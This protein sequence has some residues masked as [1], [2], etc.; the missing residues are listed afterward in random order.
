MIPIVIPVYGK[1]DHLARCLT[2]I[3]KNSGHQEPQVILVDDLGPE[4]I[5]AEWL[6]SIEGYEQLTIP[7]VIRNRRN[8]GY[9]GATNA[10]ILHAL[11]R[12]SGWRFLVLLNTDTEPLPSW[13]AS[14]ADT[15]EKA[16]GV[17]VI[18][19]KLLKADDPDQI[20]HGGTMDLLGSH[21]GG[22]ESLGHC[23]KRTD[24][25]WVTGA[26][27]A[28]TR[29][30]LQD[31]G[32]LDRGY[33]HFCSDSDYCLTA[34]SRG[35]RVIYQPE[36]RVLHGHSVTVREAVKPEKIAQDQQRLLDK[37]GGN[38]LQEWLKELP[39]G[40]YRGQPLNATR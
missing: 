19:A 7:V 18:G 24:E 13:L 30:C 1:L 10:G 26:C 5:D 37:W 16:H 25:V 40:L 23:A 34:R 6:R 35:Y 22:R 3:A 14:L 39:M 9:T 15:V 38:M 28:I 2:A 11:W 20:I 12:L 8:L 27:L 36:C 32:L 4:T 21:K 31:C 33:L 29:E 17:G